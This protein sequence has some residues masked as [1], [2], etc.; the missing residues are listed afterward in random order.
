MISPQRAPVRP[1]V[2]LPE[3]NDTIPLEDLVREFQGR[4]GEALAIIG[5]AGSGK[6][7]E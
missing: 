7:T 2:I 4:L 3:T 6:T 5:G 1:R